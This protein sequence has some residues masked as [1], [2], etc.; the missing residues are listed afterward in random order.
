MGY[1]KT[2]GVCEDAACGS[3][4]GRP[5]TNLVQFSIVSRDETTHQKSHLLFSKIVLKY[6][7][8][9]VAFQNFSGKRGRGREKRAGRE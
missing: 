2:D 3:G 4:I 7:Y 6:T 8:S 5:V 1:R 9:E